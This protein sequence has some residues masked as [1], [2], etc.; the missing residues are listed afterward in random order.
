MQENDIVG[1]HYNMSETTRTQQNRRYFLLRPTKITNKQNVTLMPVCKI[2]FFL[3]KNQQLIVQL[4][5]CVSDKPVQTPNL[6]VLFNSLANAVYI[7]G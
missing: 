6:N 1:K 5:P 7:K 3:N 4:K 2:T